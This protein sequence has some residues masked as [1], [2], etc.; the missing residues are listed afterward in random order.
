MLKSPPKRAA[1]LR[2]LLQAT[3]I[4]LLPS[5]GMAVEV[6]ETPNCSSLE[7]CL[8]IISELSPASEKGI[9]QRVQKT[10]KIL[11][12]YGRPAVTQLL[13]LLQ[14][15]EESVRARAGYVLAGMKDM[16]P[17]DLPSL[18]IAMILGNGWVPRA[19][20]KIGTPAAYRALVDNLRLD[21]QI[22]TQ[23]TMAMIAGGEKAI[24][25]L[26][27]AIS[28]D[29][30]CPDPE[31]FR[32]IAFV[33][34]EMNAKA[35]P[36]ANPLMDIASDKSKSNVIRIAALM[37]IEEIGPYAKGVREPLR[38]L[39]KSG[40]HQIA[41]SAGETLAAIGDASAVPALLAKLKKSHDRWSSFLVLRDI[42]ALGEEGKSAGPELVAILNDT[43][44]QR[45]SSAAET[46]GWIGYRDGIPALITAAQSQDWELAYQ[47]AWSLGQLR[48]IEA[49]ES[50]TRLRD[51]HWSY[52]V[53]TTASKSLELLD[54]PLPNYAPV[55]GQK[56]VDKFMS[57]Q[58]LISMAPT[59]DSDI[60]WKGNQL[61]LENHPIWP[62]PKSRKSVPK[63]IDTDRAIVYPITKGWLVGVSHGEFCGN[64][65]KG[66]LG[67]GLHYFNLKG[68]HFR[69]SEGN[70]RGIYQTSKGLVFTEGLDHM[71]YS[72]GHVFQLIP[73]KTDGW[74][75]R[76]LAILQAMPRKTAITT[77]GTLII[78]TQGSVVA[79][80]DG[81]KLEAVDCLNSKQL[82]R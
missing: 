59:C 74:Q 79:V 69:L 13:G 42:S 64:V 81:G 38:L 52:V 19:I 36:A 32:A 46:L 49:R 34:D 71:M 24:P 31:F 29:P 76:E 80:T 43:R 21:P 56:V 7:S 17:D 6:D 35:A 8:A 12:N 67:C 63:F 75:T 45:K 4:A 15:P 70:V 2:L 47:A 40:N 39:K 33:L 65:A 68:K 28:C 16:L 30:A 62:Q 1:R 50:L 20:G 26:L 14:S 61:K 54:Q 27:E 9:N 82:S 11:Q 78:Q 22:Q 25:F 37:M 58:Q 57:L 72:P 66:Y 44:N 10:A 3:V 73:K 55:K 41:H 53:K 48:A 18:K 5:S 51:E 60:A 23:T 77:D